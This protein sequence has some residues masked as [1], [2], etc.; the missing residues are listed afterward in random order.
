M[1]GGAGISSLNTGMTGMRLVLLSMFVALSYGN[2]LVSE[3]VH[4][5]APVIEIETPPLYLPDAKTVRLATLGF[6]PFFSDVLWFSTVNYFGKQFRGN[7]DYRWLRQ[8]CELVLE[9]QPKAAERYEFCATLLSWVAK[10]VNGSNLILDRATAAYPDDWRYYYL[11][12]F[13]RFY[14]QKDL[15]AG[16]EELKHAVALPNAPQM[17]ASLASRLLSD[18]PLAAVQFLQDSLKRTPDP[19]AKQALSER[20]LQAKLTYELHLLSALADKYQ[21]EKGSYPLSLEALRD[22]GYIGFLPQD[23]Y[24][25]EY[26]IDFTNKVV[27]TTSGKKP[28]QLNLNTPQTA[29]SE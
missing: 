21:V 2:L 25:G 10:D 19:S 27:T 23:P 3:K 13:N 18:D 1:L 11:R 16:A 26:R 17:L 15:A 5:A 9:L 4:R 22:A 14:F 28:L 20:L 7:G 29:N 24:G 8:R 6:N 12:G